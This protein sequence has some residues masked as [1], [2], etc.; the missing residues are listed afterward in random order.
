MREEFDFGRVVLEGCRND[1]TVEF[2]MTIATDTKGSANRIENAAHVSTLATQV[3]NL[4]TRIQVRLALFHQRYPVVRFV[5]REAAAEIAIVS[6]VGQA[7]LGETRAVER[8]RNDTI[9]CL[10]VARPTT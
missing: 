7:D 1:V 4:A 2:I 3:E 5:I 9:G 6:G 10:V 8:I